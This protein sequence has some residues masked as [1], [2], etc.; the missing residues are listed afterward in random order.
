MKLKMTLIAFL[1]MVLWM[2]PA[3]SDNN[4]DDDSNNGG[5][6]PEQAVLSA[7]SAKYA[8]ALNVE[9]EAKGDYWE[10]DFDL[11][12]VDYDAWFGKTGVWLREEYEVNYNDVPQPV[13]TSTL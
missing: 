6:Q 7:F 13:K 2:L 5:N 12:S 9:W 10:A 4:D 8:G 11:G 1:G 3:C